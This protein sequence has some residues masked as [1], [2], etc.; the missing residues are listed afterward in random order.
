M[1]SPKIIYPIFPITIVFELQYLPFPM[2]TLHPT[3]PLVPFDVAM[4]ILILTIAAG[5]GMNTNQTYASYDSFRA[6]FCKYRSISTS[7]THTMFGLRFDCLSQEFIMVALRDL[8]SLLCC[9]I[10]TILLL[11]C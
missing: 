3:P 7:S 5:E 9:N 2:V 4:P 6:A 11:V 10:F 1:P 8:K